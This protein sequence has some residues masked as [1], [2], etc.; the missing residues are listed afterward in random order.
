MVFPAVVHG[1]RLPYSRAAGTHDR[2]MLPMVKGGGVG[3]N[4]G[5]GHGGGSYGGRGD[6][7]GAGRDV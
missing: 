7:G 2:G 5:G 1:V 4:G 3:C 6:G